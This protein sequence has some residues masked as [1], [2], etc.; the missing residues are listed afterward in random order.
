MPRRNPEC[1]QRSVLPLPGLGASD[2][3]DADEAAH[4]EL[5]A[6]LGER[7]LA[8]VDLA[9]FRIED[10]AAAPLVVAG[11]AQAGQDGHA[12]Q[13]LVLACVG[14][15]V[16]DARLAV[17]VDEAL[18][19]AS[20][21]DAVLLGDLHQ[22]ARLAGVVVDGLP[23]AGGRGLRQRR[24]AAEQGGGKHRGAHGAGD[25]GRAAHDV[26]FEVRSDANLLGQP[27]R[28][29]PARTRARRSAALAW[30]PPG[31][32]QRAF[33]G[34]CGAAKRAC[35]RLLKQSSKR[36]YDPPRATSPRPSRRRER[37]RNARRACSASRGTTR[38]H[39]SD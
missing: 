28:R 38:P 22:P 33:A 35:A 31:R 13:R 9:V 32:M 34:Y 29:N 11:L 21:V 2:Q 25:K 5:V 6:I 7:H 23:R 1:R 8:L 27:P 12:D 37:I 4:V 20:A 10:L 24:G 36:T 14:A 26:S 16:A 18:E 15:L 3:A 30:F 39:R 19:Q 17:A